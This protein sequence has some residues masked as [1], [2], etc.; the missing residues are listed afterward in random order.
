MRPPDPLVVLQNDALHA[1]DEANAGPVKMTIAIAVITQTDAA[2]AD[3]HTI[4][5]LSHLSELPGGRSVVT[6]ETGSGPVPP[7]LEPVRFVRPGQAKA[8]DERH[9][10]VHSPSSFRPHGV[11]RLVER[12]LSLE[13][14]KTEG[15]EVGCINDLGQVLLI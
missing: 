12:Y 8:A 13:N 7:Y 3:F 15:G 10:A 9:H 6:T 11:N 2:R 4:V 1:D 14:I 5:S